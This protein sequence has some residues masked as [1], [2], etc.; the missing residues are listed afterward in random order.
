MVTLSAFNHIYSIIIIILVFYI[1][2]CFSLCLVQ[3]LRASN[4]TTVK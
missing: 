1:A 4:Y 3:K 2:L